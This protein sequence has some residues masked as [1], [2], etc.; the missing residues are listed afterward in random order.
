MD[1]CFNTPLKASRPQAMGASSPSSLLGFSSPRT[2]SRLEQQQQQQQLL[3]HSGGSSRGSDE[4]EEEEEVGDGRNLALSPPPSLPDRYI[5]DRGTRDMTLSSF[6]LT[7]KE[8]MTPVLAMCSQHQQQQGGGNGNGSDSTGLISGDGSPSPSSLRGE[9]GSPVPPL[10][11]YQEQQQY[12]HSYR[13]QQQRQG[14]YVGSGR[15]RSPSV[16]GTGTGGSPLGATLRRPSF[17]RASLTRLQ[18]GGGVSISP[19]RADSVS[20]AV[21]DAFAKLRLGSTSPRPAHHHHLRRGAS[22]FRSARSM[23]MDDDLHSGIGDGGY[24]VGAAAS[25]VSSGLRGCGGGASITAMDLEPYTCKL[26]RTLFSDAPQTSVLGGASGGG[27]DFNVSLNNTNANGSGPFRY[28]PVPSGSSSGGGGGSAPGAFGRSLAVVYECNR[29]R[30]FTSRSFRVIAQTPE[31]ILDAADMVDDFYMNL[32]DWSARDLLAVALRSVVYLWDAATCSIAQLPQRPPDTT[33]TSSSHS[34]ASLV[35]GLNWSPDGHHLAVGHLDGAVD[36]WDVESQTVVRQF[37]QHTAR[38]GS[39]SWTCGGGVLATGSKDTTI[40]VQDLR[41][42]QS[43]VSVLRAHEGEVCGLKWSPGRVLLASGGNDNQLLIWDR[44][45]LHSESD[46]SGNEEAAAHHYSGGSPP[47]VLGLYGNRSTQ[48]VLYLNQH[49][50]A[51]KAIA[52]NPVQTSVL[53]SGGGS[54][55]KTLRFWNTATGE[56][57]RAVD[58]ESQVCGVLWAHSGT[59]LVTSHGF[60]QNQLTIW[61]YPSLRRVADLTGH[62][63]RVLHLCMSADGETVVSAAGDE[64]IRFWRCFPPSEGPRGGGGGA[65]AAGGSSAAAAS[66]RG[67]PHSPFPTAPGTP[68]SLM[69][70]GGSGT[71]WAA[72][73]AN[74]AAG[75]AMATNSDGRHFDPISLSDELSLR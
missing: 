33:T 20:S 62:T 46:H 38:V 63:S 6:L 55:D 57:T 56:C 11:T 45:M 75:H 60:S 26:A 70:G 5:P 19:G 41:V 66:A 59:E 2:P 40:R 51:V 35:S 3:Y 28:S 30:N 73:E 4:N 18:R 32:V 7:S 9:L 49:V 74:A 24:S 10:P 16:G 12:H 14:S 13:Q 48:P 25:P 23:S 50:A 34:A 67:G 52:W 1:V 65:G 31:R 53:A 22:G 58:T 21:S 29:A 36:V 61:K 8:N 27:G 47:S 39:L 71:R 68:A 64:T 17:R 69:A 44:R 72:A 54:D 37:R 42:R 15:G 43:L